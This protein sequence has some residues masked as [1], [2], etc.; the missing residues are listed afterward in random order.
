MLNQGRETAAALDVH[1][2]CDDHFA[3]LL[4]SE[5]EPEIVVRLEVFEQGV[6]LEPGPRA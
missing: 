6:G 5:A 4:T 1:V 3:A 2:D